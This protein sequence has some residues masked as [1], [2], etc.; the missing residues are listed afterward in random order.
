MSTF[1]GLFPS[2]SKDLLF[3]LLKF[4]NNYFVFISTLKIKNSECLLRLV[5]KFC[6]IV[7]SDSLRKHDYHVV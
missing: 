7:V 1:D 6:G 3:T 5:R 2:A 4:M